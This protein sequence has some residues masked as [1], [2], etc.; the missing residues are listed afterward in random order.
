MNR[1]RKHGPTRVRQLVGPSFQV[2]E[3]QLHEKENQQAIE[4]QKM[5]LLKIVA[6][7]SNGTV[8]NSDEQEENLLHTGKF[9]T[10]W[11][12]RYIAK[13]RYNSEISLCSEIFYL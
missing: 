10:Y 3:N 6:A 5:G 7:G 13:F 2:Q 9:T 8:A 1:G 11:K 4:H 12:I